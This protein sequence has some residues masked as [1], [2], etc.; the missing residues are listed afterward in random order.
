MGAWE[1]SDHGGNALRGEFGIDGNVG[2]TG[3][4]DREQPDDHF[5]GALYGNAG[6]NLGAHADLL[7]MTG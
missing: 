5:R 1:S 2:A 3:F 4:Q 6:Q 7:Q